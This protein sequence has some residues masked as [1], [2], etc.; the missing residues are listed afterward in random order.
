MFALAQ[1]GARL[2]NSCG[3]GLMAKSPR[4]VVAG[5]GVIIWVRTDL[6]FCVTVSGRLSV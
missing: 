6:I 3:F 2:C 4:M 1:R 5:A